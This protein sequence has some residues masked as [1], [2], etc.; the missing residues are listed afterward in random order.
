ML[1]IHCLS[2]TTEIQLNSLSYHMQSYTK[3][4]TDMKSYSMQVYKT[5]QTDY[6]KNCP[7]ISI[8]SSCRHVHNT[9]KTYNLVSLTKGDLLLSN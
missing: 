4:Q 1:A 2:I 3:F 8:I 7:C 5:F 6:N 9:T